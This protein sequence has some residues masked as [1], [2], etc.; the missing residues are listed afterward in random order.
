MSLSEIR[1]FVRKNSNNHTSRLK[2]RL[3]VSGHEPKL[4]SF[5]FLGLSRGRGW[6]APFFRRGTP[7]TVSPR[8]ES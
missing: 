8:Y 2:V 7:R 6:S 1:E 3:I 4:K 5:V